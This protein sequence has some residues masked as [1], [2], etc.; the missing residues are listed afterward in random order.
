MLQS[1]AAARRYRYDRAGVVADAAAA[2]VAAAAVDG[3]A[4]DHTENQISTMFILNGL[5]VKSGSRAGGRAGSPRP[6]A[7]LLVLLGQG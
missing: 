5:G 1:P 4:L 3:L 2:A 7:D 6:P